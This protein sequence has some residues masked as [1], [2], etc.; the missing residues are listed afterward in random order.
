MESAVRKQSLALRLQSGKRRCLGRLDY[1]QGF[2]LYV[3]IPF[4]PSICSYCSFSSSPL[5]EWK[6]R[7]DDYLEALCQEIRALGEL[8]GG[9]KLN[10]IY[11]G[12]GT[13]TTLEAGADAASSG[14]DTEVIFI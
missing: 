2:S 11:I 5:E 14:Y 4:C 9:R 8:A 3:M 12:G 1:E 13:P 6:D 7:V 10:T